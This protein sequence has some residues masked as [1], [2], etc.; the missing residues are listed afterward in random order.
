MPVHTYVFANSSIVKGSEKDGIQFLIWLCR[1]Y[2]NVGE[3]FIK[4]L[5]GTP[6]D[7]ASSSHRD[8]QEVRCSAFSRFSRFHLERNLV[9]WNSE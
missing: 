1:G 9:S 3:G 2:G 6:V 7:S 5:T 4:N 8:G